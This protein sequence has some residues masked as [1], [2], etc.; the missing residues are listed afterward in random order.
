MGAI[1]SSAPIVGVIPAVA[2]EEISNGG[3]SRFAI[4]K[5]FINLFYAEPATPRYIHYLNDEGVLSCDIED[6]NGHV[7]K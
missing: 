5:F 6:D 4:D 1:E 2:S 7:S 3:K